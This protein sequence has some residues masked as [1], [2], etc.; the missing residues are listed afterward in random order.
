MARPSGRKELLSNAPNYGFEFAMQALGLGKLEYLN[1]CHQLWRQQPTYRDAQ[2]VVCGCKLW[3]GHLMG[4]NALRTGKKVQALLPY[5][6]YRE[7]ITRVDER[8]QVQHRSGNGS[9]I[10]PQTWR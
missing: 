1:V 2:S 4:V 9:Y 10:T 5:H 8:D 6:S 7:K 3:Q